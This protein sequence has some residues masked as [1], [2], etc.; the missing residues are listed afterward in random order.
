MRKYKKT[1][2]EMKNQTNIKQTRKN[3]VCKSPSLWVT[4]GLKDQPVCRR[5]SL[6]K[7][8]EKRKFVLFSEKVGQ[9]AIEFYGQ[10]SWTSIKS[11]LS[12]RLAGPLC[13]LCSLWFKWL[14][15][16]LTCF[17]TVLVLSSLWWRSMTWL[18]YKYGT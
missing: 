10:I 3:F 6:S 1:E 5:A 12:K 7:R 4:K 8:F 17:K 16:K 11:T 13:L 14:H 2:T 9:Y 15:I 18:Y